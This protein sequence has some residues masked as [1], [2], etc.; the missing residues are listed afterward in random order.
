MSPNTLKKNIGGHTESH[1]SYSINSSTEEEM[2]M[3]VT[4]ERLANVGE[5]LR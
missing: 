3:H 5:S 4:Q 2:K 1:S